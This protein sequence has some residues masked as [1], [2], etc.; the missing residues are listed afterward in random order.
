M[1][2]DGDKPRHKEHNPKHVTRKG[3][4]E[5]ASGLQTSGGQMGK[6]AEEFFLLSFP[7][8]MN[9]LEM[10]L[11]SIWENRTIWDHWSEL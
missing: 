5:W 10:V 11:K 8:Q 1:N 6:R 2:E 4:S 3:P 7:T 9:A